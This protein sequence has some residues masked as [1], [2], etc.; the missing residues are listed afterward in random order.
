MLTHL[1]AS[2]SWNWNGSTPSGTVAEKKTEGEASVT[3]KRGNVIKK[4]AKP[5]DPAIA[6]SRSG[7]DVVK[8]QSE[9]EVEEKHPDNVNGA[10]SKQDQEAEE[11]EN[12]ITGAET[13]IEGGEIEEDDEDPHEEA[14]AAIESGKTKKTPAKKSTGA[15]PKKSTGGAGTKRKA[16]ADAEPS[17]SKKAKSTAT[18]PSKTAAAAKK[19]KPASGKGEV[20]RGRPKGS[21][22]ATKKAA[23]T[24][25]A[26]ERK[27]RGRPKKEA[28]AKVTKPAA[29]AKKATTGK[30][31]GDSKE[32]KA[33]KA[34]GGKKG[35][36]A[37]AG[38]KR[39]RNP[40]A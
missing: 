28:E 27:P 37:T 2:A 36:E 21:T 25:A 1:P 16:D 23:T 32:T 39:G 5:D 14:M 6:L 29:K 35:G 11:D 33:K 40:K 4:A 22:N 38:K 17:S 30:K 15:T 13:G 12:V 24:T 10:K 31:G 9:L 18:T 7:N 20:K 8:N 19:D 26:G 34:A 3:S